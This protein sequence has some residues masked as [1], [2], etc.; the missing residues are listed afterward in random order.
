MSE[1][2]ELKIEKSCPVASAHTRLRQKH[3]TL[4][5][6]DG[7]PPLRNP[8]TPRPAAARTFKLLV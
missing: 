2:G 6:V 4:A 8:R 7:R 3:P 1:S 5:N